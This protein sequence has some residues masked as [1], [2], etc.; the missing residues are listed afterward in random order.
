M[1]T[2]EAKPTLGLIFMDPMYRNIL[3][4]VLK[5]VQSYKKAIFWTLFK[6][7]K[8][9]N[10]HL[11][12][13]VIKYNRNSIKKSLRHMLL[14]CGRF[15]ILPFSVF[16]GPYQNHKIIKNYKYVLRSQS[17]EIFSRYLDIANG[18]CSCFRQLYEECYNLE[19]IKTVCAEDPCPIIT[20]AVRAN[21]LVVFCYLLN[22]L[23]VDILNNQ[24]IFFF[25]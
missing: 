18:F 24:N 14:E 1:E 6:T 22:E 21:N 19:I 13:I 25:M 9:M 12:D 16:Y 3:N 5:F 8:H 10:K 4:E 17:Y 2:T 11:E 23:K 15:E 7:N 20:D